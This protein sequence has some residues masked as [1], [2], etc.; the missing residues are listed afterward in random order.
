MIAAAKA[1]V[2]EAAVREAAVEMTAAE[3]AVVVTTV[4]GALAGATAM[5]K[6]NHAVS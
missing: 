2:R 6:I 5:R 3:M 4:A 1:A